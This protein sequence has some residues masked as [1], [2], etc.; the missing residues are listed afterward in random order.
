MEEWE[1][2][3]RRR[4]CGQRTAAQALLEDSRRR[5]C[6]QRTAAQALLEDS[7]RRRCGQRTAPQPFTIFSS[8]FDLLF[9]KGGNISGVKNQLGHLLFLVPTL[10]QN[11]K[12]STVKKSDQ[13]K[14]FA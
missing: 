3:S 7:R 5:R 12:P 9:F 6:G 10:R 11:Y 1:G 13:P 4:R 2:C 14:D 8:L